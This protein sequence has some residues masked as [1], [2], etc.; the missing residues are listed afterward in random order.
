MKCTLV[1]WSKCVQ[2]G[3]GG[4]GDG[5]GTGR[6][7]GMIPDS[8]RVA[9]NWLSHVRIRTQSEARVYV[10]ITVH[11][12]NPRASCMVITVRPEFMVIVS[13]IRRI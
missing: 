10:V 4:G 9:T 12:Y 13:A 2:D 7:I 3:V 8:S 1:S 5:N 11:G 6:V